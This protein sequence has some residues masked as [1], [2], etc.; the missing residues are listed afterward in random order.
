M[1]PE[2]GNE[3]SQGKS[4]TAPGAKT[5][6]TSETT[7]G[8][9]TPPTSETAAEPKSPAA[10]EAAATSKVSAAAKLLRY[11]KLT[12]KVLGISALAYLILVPIF[13]P[14]L[15]RLYANLP[16]FLI[17]AGG[18]VGGLVVSRKSSKDG[19]PRLL[20][21]SVL[22]GAV[23]SLGV[24]A[25]C[26]N[27]IQ[28]IVDWQMA[29]SMDI[30]EL[31]AQPVTK[32]NRI[33]PR[34]IALEL[35]KGDN[36]DGRLNA[37]NPQI[38]RA[39][40]NG[41]SKV[42]WVSPLPFAKTSQVP[43]IYSFIYGKVLGSVDKVVKVDAKEQTVDLKSGQNAFFW[44]GHDSFVTSVLF[45]LRHPFSR[46]GEYVYWQKPDGSWSF[47]RS[48]T[49]YKMTWTLTMV[50]T[51][52]GVMEF[53]PRGGFTNHSVAQASEHFKGASLYPPELTRAYSQAYARFHKGAWNYWMEQK[54]IYEISEDDAKDAHSNN[55]LP[56]FEDFEGLGLQQYVAFEPVGTSS[57]ALRELLYFDSVSGKVHR[58]VMKDDGTPAI[59]PR[60]AMHDVVSADWDTPWQNYRRIEPLI[61]NG[62][63]GMYF[64]VFV[65]KDSKDDHGAS[66]RYVLVNARERKNNAKKFDTA[67]EL[68]EYLG[69]P[70]PAR[71]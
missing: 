58:Y 23:L 54:D 41:Q 13:Q 21:W 45:R 7:A 53:G 3:N 5:P 20:A 26:S 44:F 25:W 36:T 38:V 34:P 71:K 40:E 70:L 57:Y 8:A 59:G 24:F 28:W 22:V 14:L 68:F 19:K 18:I 30:S 27:N 33:V 11:T 47:L 10:S 63:K 31:D 56:Y 16:F 62:K 6:A 2:N 67:E 15:V 64:L 66:V 32:N 52:S 42:Y 39:E 37:C 55:S 60:K 49:S 65:L 1:N 46:E 9:K 12:L 17:A 48:Y 61:V 35:I 69:E 51:V 4:E 43:N 29:S 50:P